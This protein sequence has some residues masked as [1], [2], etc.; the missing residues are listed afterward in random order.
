MHKLSSLISLVLCGILLLSNNAHAAAAMGDM[1]GDMGMG[2]VHA[3]TAHN[4]AVHS[5]HA[6]TVHIA[7]RHV[8][9]ATAHLPTVH[10]PTLHATAHATIH[11]PS[12]AHVAPVPSPSTCWPSCFFSFFS[13]SLS[14]A[15][16]FFLPPLFCF[17]RTLDQIQF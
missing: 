2:T 13:L 12:T 15:Q 16:F 10:S 8:V 1:G 17:F 6:A 3:V 5:V 14:P 4:P 7:T 11:G 9:A